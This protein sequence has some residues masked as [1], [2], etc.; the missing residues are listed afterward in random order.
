MAKMTA[1]IAEK[2]ITNT[3]LSLE[4]KELNPEYITAKIILNKKKITMF[5]LTLLVS[6]IGS[7]RKGWNNVVAINKNKKLKL[8]SYKY[9]DV[10]CTSERLNAPLKYT[11]LI[12][13]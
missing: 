1:L 8:N 11:N 7:V 2:Y 4:L 5:N 10:C 9:A 12:I 6:L 3:A 13:S